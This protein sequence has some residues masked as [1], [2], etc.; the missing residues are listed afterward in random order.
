M[1]PSRKKLLAT[2]DALAPDARRMLEAVT[3]FAELPLRETR[4]SAALSSFLEGRGFRVVRGIAGMATAFRAEFR[5]GRGRPRV[6][7]LCE[8]DALPGI[9]HACG[10]NIGGIASACAAAALASFGAGRFRS[11]SVVALG[12]PAEEM[13]YGKARMVKE[14]VFRGIDAAMM[15]HPSSRRHVAKGYLALHKVRFTYRGKASHAAAYPEHGINALDGVLLLFQGIAAL[16][17]HLPETVKVHGIV[18]DG[19][20]APNIVPERAQA[21]FYVRGEDDAQLLETVPRVKACARAAAKAT[22]CRL[23]IEEGQYTRSAMKVNPDVSTVRL[24]VWFTLR[25]SNSSNPIF[26]V[27]LRF[28]RTRSKITIVSFTE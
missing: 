22:G 20:P 7:L 5:F 24:N 17:Q 6:A 11:G 14:G 13:G 12:T 21:Y 26:L 3:G 25:L 19:G 4:T 28:S 18:T 10:H 15:V 1:D 16:R 2:A 8:M 27:S 23:E 9:G